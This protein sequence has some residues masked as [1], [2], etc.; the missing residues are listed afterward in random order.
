M[1]SDLI[2][3]RKKLQKELSDIHWKIINELKRQKITPQILELIEYL[4]S[5][6]NGWLILGYQDIADD[7]FTITVDT[8]MATAL[9]DV[10]EKFKLL[11]ID[12]N[13]SATQ[14][15][16]TFTKIKSF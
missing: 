8:S 4:Q 9:P 7:M 13:K 10:L 3:Q 11:V 15:T 14:Y 1:I 16:Y 12:I 2:E 6:E 5:P